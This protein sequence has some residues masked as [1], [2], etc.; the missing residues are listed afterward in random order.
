[1]LHPSLGL[2]C[3]KCFCSSRLGTRAGLILI[4]P[5]LLHKLAVPKA[6]LFKVFLIKVL[7]ALNQQ[8]SALPALALLFL[9]TVSFRL[10]LEVPGELEYPSGLLAGGKVSL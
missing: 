6:L 4:P 1:M 9:E 5:Y 3:N 10:S 8:P 7:T 2:W